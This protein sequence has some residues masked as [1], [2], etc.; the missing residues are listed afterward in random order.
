MPEF[1]CWSES[2]SSSHPPIM[3]PW[4]SCGRTTKAAFVYG[5]VTYT[6][7]PGP[8]WVGPC[9][10]CPFP[11]GT[12]NVVWTPLHNC[13][14]IY[15]TTGH[16]IAVGCVLPALASAEYVPSTR[17]FAFETNY[18]KLSEST[19][20]CM[21]TAPNGPWVY[22][23]GYSGFICVGGTGGDCSGGTICRMDV[24]ILGVG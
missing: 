13:S 11:V 12:Y 9:T 1:I 5:T 14:N 2:P 18:I 23:G 6:C 24:L 17:L 4:P 21:W 3:R 7:I 8:G 10:A 20:G 19:G 22:R 16:P 15:V